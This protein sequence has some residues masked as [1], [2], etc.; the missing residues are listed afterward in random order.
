MLNL[1]EKSKLI[2]LALVT[3]NNVKLIIAENPKVYSQ[4]KSKSRVLS[5]TKKTNIVSLM[6]PLSL[7]F[8]PIARLEL[9]DT[10][11]E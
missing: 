9:E 11:E 10:L 1:F 6:E 2:I 5:P 4:G 7:L 3:L 8:A